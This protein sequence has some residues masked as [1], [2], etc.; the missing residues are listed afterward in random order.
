[1]KNSR[2]RPMLAGGLIQLSSAAAERDFSLLTNSFNER[3][4]SS[5]GLL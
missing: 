4:N 5:L 1:M 2:E 3:Q